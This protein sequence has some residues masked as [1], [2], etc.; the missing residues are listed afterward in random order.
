[1]G[2]ISHLVHPSSCGRDEEWKCSFCLITKKSSWQVTV[3]R[4][5]AIKHKLQCEADTHH[6]TWGL[7]MKGTCV[8]ELWPA[9]RW[10]QMTF[11]VMTRGVLFFLLAINPEQNC[12][13]LLWTASMEKLWLVCIAHTT[14]RILKDCNSYLFNLELR[15]LMLIKCQLHPWDDWLSNFPDWDEW[16]TSILFYDCIRWLND[17]AISAAAIILIRLLL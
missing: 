16:S 1:M 12:Q 3:W 14:E 17:T 4:P 6:Y 7:Q 10:G 5:L 11:T 13:H 15:T 8:P 9:L 2:Q